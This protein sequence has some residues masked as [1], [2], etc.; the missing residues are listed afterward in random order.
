M[1]GIYIHIPFCRRKCHYCNFF[2]L[3][4]T[5]YKDRFLDT[6]KEE[7]YLRKDY[8]GGNQVQSIYLGGGTPS[9]LKMEEVN[10]ILEFIR[11]Y[12]LLGENSEISL[13]ANPDDINPDL[14]HNYLDI[15]INRISIGVQSFFDDD[16]QYLNRIHSGLRAEESVLQAKNAGFTNISIDLIYAIPTLT[17]EKWKQ[18]LEKAFFL[19]IPHISA[20]SLTVEPR[21][22]LDLLIRKKKLPG[23]VE[24][25]FLDHFRIMIKMMKEQGFE[26]Y[27]ISNFCRERSYSRHNSMYWNGT[28]YLG[29]GPSA[30]SYN[31]TSRQ[32]NISNIVQYVDQINR[33]EPFFESEELTDIQ[34]Y[35]EYVMVSL[36]T[37]WGCDLKTISERFGEESASYFS[38]SAAP[39][40]KS[41]EITEKSSIYYL[42]DEGKLFADGIASNLFY[43]S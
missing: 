26:Y 3:A 22:A 37:M 40:L 27:E 42:T 17:Q 36:R 31:G 24:E 1:S 29:L 19:D 23:P 38:K 9:I 20:Y 32:W 12:F 8:L 10:S 43:E 33:N 21:T 30:H 13:E 39:Y 41:G 18:N 2:S 11:K 25:D 4:S 6:L 5:K 28:P 14:L 15:G 35:N 16:L 34:K 7:I